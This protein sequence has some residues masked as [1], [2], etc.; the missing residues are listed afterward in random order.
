[1]DCLT[2]AASFTSH[3]THKTIAPSFSKLWPGKA[4]SNVPPIRQPFELLHVVYKKMGIND[5]EETGIV[6]I[7]LPLPNLPKKQQIRSPNLIFDFMKKI[8]DASKE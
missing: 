2:V 4:N 6:A 8:N 3:Q 7:Q 5:L 1:M